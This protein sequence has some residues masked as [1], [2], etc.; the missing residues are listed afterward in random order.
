MRTPCPPSR[1]KRYRLA[2]VCLLLLSLA[3]WT[4]TRS[5][6][7]LEDENWKGALQQFQAAFQAAGEDVRYYSG[8]LSLESKDFKK[9]L[10]R[11]EKKKGQ[12]MLWFTGSYDPED[13]HHLLKG[14][15][16]LRHQGE[17]L[18]K[19][20]SEAERSLEIFGAK[21]DEIE[22][23]MR[24]QLDEIPTPEYS[25]ALN[26][27]LEN[28]AT[29]K[30]ELGKLI[31]R[32]GKTRKI[33]DRYTMRLDESERSARDKIP[34]YWR[35]F[36]LEPTPTVFSR[37]AWTHFGKDMDQWLSGLDILKES[38]Q[39]RKEWMEVRN[40]L[41][42]GLLLAVVLLF[43]GRWLTKK[44]GIKMQATGLMAQLMPGWILMTL[45]ASAILVSRTLPF[46]LYDFTAALNE[47]LFTAGMVS[48]SSFLR[49]CVRGDETGPPNRNPFWY[50]WV[51]LASGLWIKA[52]GLPYGISVVLWLLALISTG[53]KLR[54]A[55]AKAKGKLERTLAS[56][57]IAL[58][59]VMAFL[60]LV[61]FAT[62]SFTIAATFFYLLL[63]IA[64]GIEVRR[65][66][67]I[68]EARARE[69]GKSVFLIGCIS[70]IG[71]PGCI[72]GFFLLNVWL[73]SFRFG[74]DQVFFEM[75][76]FKV[77]WRDFSMSPK[78]IT[79]IV[80]GFYLTKTAIFFSDAFFARL[81]Q[82]RPDLDQVVVESLLT[83]TRYVWWAF[84]CLYMLFLLGI[85]LTSLA[86]I[87]GGLSVGIGFGLQHI[88]NNFF[89]G[90]ILLAGRSIQSGDTIEIGNVLGDVRKVT[91][92]NTVVQT[93]EN[94]TLFVPN[95]D[96]ITNR[97]VNW[98]HRDRRV[99]RVINVGVAYGSDTEKVTKLLREATMSHPSVLS[100][101]LPEVLFW[102]FGASTLDFR[103]KFW[104]EDVGNDMRVLSDIRYEIDRVFR[105]NGI[106][107]AYPQSDIHLRTA[108]ALEKLWTGEK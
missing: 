9:G 97:L 62:I 8:K 36:Y 93:R 84:F 92:R 98:S 26:S 22:A 63:T 69:S 30:A 4:G 88:V 47:I 89:S 23:E 11:L 99:V 51:L 38:L 94:A 56:W 42:H 20:F 18:F 29:L 79:F 21:L 14:I 31:D 49:L 74:G 95:S 33:Y 40:A 15:Q 75:L 17:N 52:L 102:D 27:N 70:G 85:D 66:L 100:Q 7:A 1:C 19:P 96:L 50:Y 28:I 16:R 87:A 76:S 35:I 6:S 41:I 58:F 86:V 80:M 46:T 65:L 54:W 103:V 39:G 91:I 107:I 3:L 53:L 90:L 43:L 71:F 2:V 55:T 72:V 67:I 13:I 25:D 78:E 32:V 60:T 108:P 34:T 77:N 73:L 64:I 45:C 81:P 24:R 68:W 101:P 5:V 48:L 105:K 104:I 106:E 82:F 57:T 12:M 83:L 10:A 44:V 61:G 59:S 37:D